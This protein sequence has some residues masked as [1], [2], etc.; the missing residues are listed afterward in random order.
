MELSY[1]TGG[2]LPIVI[3][4]REKAI[5][6]QIRERDAVVWST[7][8]RDR[9]S[10]PDEHTAKDAFGILTVSNRGDRGVFDVVTGITL[11]VSRIDKGSG[12]LSP[13]RLAKQ[14]PPFDFGPAFTKNFM[15][16]AETRL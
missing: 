11:L 4:P 16:P 3:E 13:M 10:W 1:D 6:V 14:I 5:I 15:S 7:Q 12:E 9:L 2:L 8:N